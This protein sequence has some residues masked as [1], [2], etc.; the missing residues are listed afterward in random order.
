MVRAGWW[1]EA[2]RRARSVSFLGSSEAPAESSFS[3]TIGVDRRCAASLTPAAPGATRRLQ[4]LLQV[5]VA[6]VEIV[7]LLAQVVLVARPVLVALVATAV[8]QAK[9]FNKRLE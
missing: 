8:Q 2:V 3:F 7:L 9:R 4:K 6:L 1:R 5:Q